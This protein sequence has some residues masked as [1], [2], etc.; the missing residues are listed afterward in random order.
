MSIS[1]CIICFNEEKNIRRCLESSKWAD[2]IIVVDSISQD[3]TVEIAKEYT[4]KVYRR[5]W[6]GFVDGKNFALSKATCEW[7]FSLDADEEIPDKLREEIREEINNEY[8]RDGYSMPRL[9]FYQGRWIKHSGFYPDRQ[10]KLFKRGKGLWVGKRVHERVEVKGGVGQLKNDLLHYPY[11]G[12]ISG[13]IQTIDAFSTLLAQDLYEQGRR[14]NSFLLLLRPPL[15]FLEVYLLR[16]G[17]LDGMAGFIIA[18][19]S[20][21]AVFVRYVK[22]REFEKEFRDRYFSFPED[23]QGEDYR[24]GH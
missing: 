24:I 22:L 8:A 18:V 1:I 10:L 20:A 4:D 19:S 14:F 23:K 2:E 9:S 7:V 12:I 13:Q 3:R 16:L 11:D 21:Y 17:F 5:A 6:S 15:K